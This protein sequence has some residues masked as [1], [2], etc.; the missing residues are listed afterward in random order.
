MSIS[1]KGAAVTSWKLTFLL[2]QKGEICSRFPWQVCL[3]LQKWQ[4]E[5]VY[6]IRRVKE[7]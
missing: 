4:S 5:Q 2:E 1:E 6:T 3:C 7:V